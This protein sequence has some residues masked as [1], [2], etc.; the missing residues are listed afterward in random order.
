MIGR[1]DLAFVAA[2]LGGAGLF[3]GGMTRN[4]IDPMIR[5]EGSVP[6]ASADPKPTFAPADAIVKSFD[7]ALADGWAEKSVSPAPVADDLTIL[8]RLTLGLQ[9]SIPSLE[10]IRAFEQMPKATRIDAWLDR[11]LRDRRTAD[12][13]AERFARAFVGVEDGPFLLFRRRRF[14]SW[15]SDNLLKNR[16]YDEI[17]HDLIADRGLWTDHPATNFITV[18]Y[19]PEKKLP[20]PD[21]LAARVSRAFLG[22]RLD[23]ARC[24]DHPFRVWK[25]K[26]FEGLAAYFGSTIS[27]LRG[28]RETEN[29]Y[30]PVDRKT[31][32]AKDVKAAVPFHRECVTEGLGPRDQLAA[33]V[34]H[35]GNPHLARATT[36]RV[37]ALM[38]GRPLVDPVDDLPADEEQPQLLKLL[39]QDFAE[40]DYDLHRLIRVIARTQAFRRS[41]SAGDDAG[42]STAAEESWAVFPLT[43]L[44]PEQVAGSVH[45]TSSVST[46]GPNNNW[47]FRAIAYGQKNDFVRR[48]GDTGEDEFSLRNGTI[49]QRLLLMNGDLVE[50]RVRSNPFNASTRIAD[51]AP[52][53]RAA[54]EVAYLTTLTRRPTSEELY[55]FASKLADKTADARKDQLA[56]LFWALE[57]SSEFSWNH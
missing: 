15:L 52:S 48:Y 2:I 45:Q 23:C 40:H 22:I 5:P 27:D 14:V 7:K 30:K 3:V 57:N 1:R 10:E 36:N 34:V 28:T 25:Q 55:H 9:G 4:P 42:P 29:F 11:I 41:S 31:Q 56:D 21:R 12:Y 18:T 54:I 13:V 50:E 39:A 24:H 33:W 35:K 49:P 53:D 6:E 20:D 38:F 47:F 46:F 37:W 32:K 44:R 43:R 19:D 8:R 51:Q 17:V 16:R 26:D